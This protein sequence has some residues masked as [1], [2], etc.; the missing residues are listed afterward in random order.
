MQCILEFKNLSVGRNNPLI[1]GFTTLVHEGSFIA[2]TGRN[3]SGKSTFLRTIAGIL[4]PLS[5]KILYAGKTAAHQGQLASLLAYAGTERVNENYI[6][7]DALV[8]LGR[9][10]FNNTHSTDADEASLNEI[11]RMTGIESVRSKYLHE[12]SDGEWQKANLA[13]VLAQRTPLILLDEPSAFLDYPSRKSLYES[14]ADLCR[15]N[16]KTIIVSTHD[17]QFAAQHKPIFW[18]LENKNCIISDRPPLWG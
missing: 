4:P 11:F 2:L 8:R 3:G 1:E 5:G 18:H 14:L 6:S 10:P 15:Q 7:V 16:N 13:R 12:I 9:F 17:P